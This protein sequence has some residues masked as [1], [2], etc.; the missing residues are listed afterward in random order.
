MK[1]RLD[2]L[3]LPA[4]APR[5]PFDRLIMA[6]AQLLGVRIVT[7]DSQFGAHEVETVPV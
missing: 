4:R 1:Y 6:Q 5:D 7:A 3:P 2:K